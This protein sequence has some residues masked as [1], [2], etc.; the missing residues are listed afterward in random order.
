MKKKRNN[1]WQKLVAANAKAAGHIA[2]K[3]IA[4]AEEAA[5]KGWQAAK[6]V[7]GSTGKEFMKGFRKGRG[8][9][10]LFG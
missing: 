1:D 3:S 10:K 5:Q 7:S 9:K 4:L 2:G 8:K 6:N